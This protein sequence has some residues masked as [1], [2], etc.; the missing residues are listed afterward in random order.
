MTWKNIR[1]GWAVLSAIA[2]FLSIHRFIGG[3][4]GH[5]VFRLLFA[6]GFLVAYHVNFPLSLS[7]KARAEW[8]RARKEGE[9]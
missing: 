9:I 7:S 3:E 4:Y 8:L 6:V 5:A 2:L 1:S